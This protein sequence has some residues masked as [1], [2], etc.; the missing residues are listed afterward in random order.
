MKIAAVCC[1]FLRP[2]QLGHLIRCFECQDY[3]NRELVI[4]DDAG[5]LGPQQG[6]RWRIYVAGRRFPNLGAK[7]NA[8]AELVAGDTEAL[9]PWDDDDLYLPWS[10]SATAA[11]LRRAAWSRPSLVLMANRNGTLRQH[12]TFHRADGTDKAFHGGW[13]YRRDVFRKAGGYP[14]TSNGEDRLLARRLRRLGVAEADPVAL[15]FAPFYV[16]GPGGDP[17]LSAAGAG[18]TGYEKWGRR[19]V[20]N[21]TVTPADPPNIDLHHPVILPEIHPRCFPGDWS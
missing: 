1:T 9:C 2:R 8:A 19:E 3:Q 14:A 21:A 15:G 11:A 18:N 6:D 20:Q 12:R 17:H 10:L 7:R 16:W 13:G 5:Q 4:L